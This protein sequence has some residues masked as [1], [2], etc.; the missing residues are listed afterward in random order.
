MRNKCKSQKGFTLVEMLVCTIT[1]VLVASICSMGIQIAMKSYHESA[2]ESNSQMLESTLNLYLSDI[3]RYASNIQT[4]EEADENGLV[5]IIGFSNTAYQ[6]R[7]GNIGLGTTEESEGKIVVFDRSQTDPACN[8]T[9]IAGKNVYPDTIY[10]T[11]LLI[12]YN[13]DTHCFEGSYKIKSEIL[14]DAERVC[15]FTCRTVLAGN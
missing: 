2:Y 12:K 10:I 3:L 13:K 9:L 4:T 11:E 15:I 7:G 5:E 1:L 6:M 8:E 14:P